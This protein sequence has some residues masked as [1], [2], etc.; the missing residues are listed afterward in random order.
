MGSYQ[1]FTTPPLRSSGQKCIQD[2]QNP[3]NTPIKIK[4]KKGG[5]GG[6]KKG[7]RKEKDKIR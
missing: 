7:R 4:K 3:I 6:N 5:G 2:S 1:E